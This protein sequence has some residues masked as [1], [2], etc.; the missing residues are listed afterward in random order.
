MKISLPTVLAL[1]G[2]L[3]CVFAADITGK[4]TLKGTPKAEIP[5]DMAATN[6]TG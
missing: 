6:N 3:Q 2:S 1:A 5:I 4:V